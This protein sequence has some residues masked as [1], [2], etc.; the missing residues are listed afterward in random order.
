VAWSKI[1]S[2][3]IL[4]FTILYGQ[5]TNS[6]VSLVENPGK[7]VVVFVRRGYIEPS[8]VKLTRE[9]FKPIHLSMLESMP[10]LGALSAAPAYLIAR[11]KHRGNR[12]SES[13]K[14]IVDGFVL[15]LILLWMGLYFQRLP[16]HAQYTVR[17][18]H[19]L[20]PLGIYLLFRLPVVRNAVSGYPRNA[21]AA[22][23]G[24]VV[25]GAG[26][27]IILLAYSGAVISEAV[28]LYALIALGVALCVTIWAFAGVLTGASPRIGATVLGV[29]TAS[30]TV[31]LLVSGFATFAYTHNYLLPVGRA[32]AELLRFVNPFS[33]LF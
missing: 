24:T 31:Y 32:I 4:P 3:V 20:Y 14:R 13:P 21:I 23:I 30:M 18:L 8:G 1:L 25:C 29:A 5:F 27:Y 12:G 10:L 6:L 33:Y 2:D 9:V 22:Y 17:Y 7:L 16:V 26:G 19:P 28:Q 11:I 15:V